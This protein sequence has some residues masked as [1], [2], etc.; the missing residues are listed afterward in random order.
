[1][2]WKCKRCDFWASDVMDMPMHLLVHGFPILYP[3]DAIRQ[4]RHESYVIREQEENAK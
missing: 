3:H 1:M 4:F 2:T